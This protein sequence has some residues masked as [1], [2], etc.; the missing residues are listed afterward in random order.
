MLWRK[1]TG[2]LAST[3]RSL[4]GSH[5]HSVLPVGQC[6]FMKLRRLKRIARKVKS[7]LPRN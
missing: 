4:D 1:H 3:K 5:Q 2:Q 6:G 7:K